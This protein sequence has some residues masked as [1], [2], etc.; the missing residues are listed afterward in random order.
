[1][2]VNE[3]LTEILTRPV[4]I[5][6]EKSSDLTQENLTKIFQHY[7]QDKNLSLEILTGKQNFLGQNDQFQSDIKKWEI[8]IIRNGEKKKL[9]FIAKTTTGEPFQQFNT[10]ITRQ[11][12]TETFWYKFA[13]PI[14]KKDFPEIAPLSPAWY[15]AYS[16]YED[17][18][19]PDCCDKSCGFFCRAFHHKNEVGIILMENACE[20]NRQ[21]GFPSMVSIDKRNVMSLNQVTAA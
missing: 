8:N 21:T 12:F 13:F 4:R 3:E 6:V 9:S 20:E 19:R 1:M 2:E 16:N 11:F 10:R 17:S 5:K 15:Y 18:F 7:F 14:L